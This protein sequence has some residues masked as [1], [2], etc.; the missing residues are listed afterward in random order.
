MARHEF[1]SC[2]M[3]ILYCSSVEEYCTVDTVDEEYSRL[4]QYLLFEFVVDEALGHPS[5]GR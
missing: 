2:L 5:L 3:Q 4:L 1:R